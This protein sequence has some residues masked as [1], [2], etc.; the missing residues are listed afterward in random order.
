MQQ[1]LDDAGMGEEIA[2]NMLGLTVPKFGVILINIDNHAALIDIQHTFLHELAHAMT[3]ADGVTCEH[4]ERSI[5][6]LGAYLHQYE[7]TKRGVYDIEME[8]STSKAT[9]AARRLK[10]NTLPRHRGDSDDRRRKEP[11]KRNKR[12]R[13]DVPSR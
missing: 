5:D 9:G 1:F 10:V 11:A 8:R 3:F 4:D 6:R 2:G 13:G 7:Q 12:S